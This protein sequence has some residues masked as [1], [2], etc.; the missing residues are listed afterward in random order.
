MNNTF[1]TWLLVAAVAGIGLLFLLGT[2]PAATTAAGASATELTTNGA[3]P[4]AVTATYW[5]P[6]SAMAPAPEASPT[7]SAASTCSSCATRPS[8]AAP[9]EVVPDVAAGATY[10]AAMHA[11]AAT[12]PPGG[13]RGGCGSPTAPCSGTPCGGAITC[14]LSSCPSCAQHSTSCGGTLP[15]PNQSA[16]DERP[17]I[18]RN[19][20]TCV[21]ECSFT[22]LYS[23]VALPICTSIRFAWAA[24][25]GQFLD[26]KSPTPIYYAPGTGLAGGEDVLI[27]LTVTDAQGHEYVDQM[28]LH[29]NDAG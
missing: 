13:L 2:P 4:G 1:I 17:L 29:I 3:A 25:R 14:G 27:T 8:A 19:G 21:D 26:P 10:V 6:T 18:N 22:Q 16:C 5:Q 15:C 7:P 12:P 23:T 24:T 9:V 20:P 11:G 28:K